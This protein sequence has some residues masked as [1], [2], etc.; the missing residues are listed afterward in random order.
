MN[1]L[2]PIEAGASPSVWLVFELFEPPAGSV[3]LPTTSYTITNPH[4][5][6][7]T[8]DRKSFAYAAGEMSPNASQSHRYNPIG[9]NAYETK[10]AS[11]ITGGSADQAAR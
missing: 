7:P 8:I 10:L 11:W 5:R 3:L 1:H 6:R 9:V 4:P 2:S